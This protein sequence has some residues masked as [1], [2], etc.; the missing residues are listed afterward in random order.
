MISFSNI[1]QLLS[2]RKRLYLKST[3]NA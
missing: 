2:I 3:L 1:I